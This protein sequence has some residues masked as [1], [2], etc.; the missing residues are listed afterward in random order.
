MGRVGWP[1]GSGGLRPAGHHRGESVHRSDAPPPSPPP[2]PPGPARGRLLQQGARLSRGLRR[3]PGVLK[4][5]GEREAPE[6][7]QMIER[8]VGVWGTGRFPRPPPICLTPGD[9]CVGDATNV[10]WHCFF[11]ISTSLRKIRHCL[12]GGESQTHTIFLISTHPGLNVEGAPLF[13]RI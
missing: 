10:A 1:G 3:G 4:A 11:L 13:L 2:P 9:D 12:Q 5:R 8:R 7:L 6:P